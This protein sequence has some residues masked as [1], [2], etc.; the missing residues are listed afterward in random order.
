MPGEYVIWGRILAA[1]GGSNSFFVAVD[2]AE[3]ALWHTRIS[4]S[5]LWD[6]VADSSGDDPLGVY[7]EAGEHTLVIKH[8]EPRT[9]ID[10]ILITNDMEYIPE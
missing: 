7:L 4:T 1:D 3:S 5:W 8:R 6:Q 2:G 9:K 10:K